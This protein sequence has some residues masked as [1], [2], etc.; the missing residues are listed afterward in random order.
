M[1]STLP[2]YENAD[3][4][5]KHFEPVQLNLYDLTFTSLPTLLSGYKEDLMSQ[6]VNTVGGIQAINPALDVV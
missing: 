1:A 4:S 3:A 5:K 6:H 2:H